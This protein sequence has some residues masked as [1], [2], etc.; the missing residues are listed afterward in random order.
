MIELIVNKDENSK[1]IAVVENGKLVEIYEENEESKKARNEGN[2]YLGIVKD[3]IPGMQ[4]AFVDI[5]TEKNSFIHVKDVIPQVDEKIE[6]RPNV[7][8]K[9][10]IKP[11]QKIL[12]QIQKDSNDKKG[13]RTSTHIK[14]T[15]KYLVLMPNTNIVTISQKIVDEK[16][17]QR[18]L[19]I[20]KVELPE[21]TGAILRTAAEHK[22]KEEIK[23]D[24]EQLMEKWEKIKT[25]FNNGK[26]SPEVLFRSP[27]IIEKIILDLP[28][29]RIEKIEV[30]DQDEYNEI[31]EM[32]V[33]M[34][35]NIKIEL[36][37][38]LLEKYELRKQIEK[39]KQRKIWLNCGGFITID[40][41]EALIA[42]V[43]NSGKFTGKSTL[44]ETIYK[45]NYEATI[46]IAKQLR[47]R[48]IGGIIIIDY[49]DMLKPENKEKIENLLKECLKQDRAKTQVEGF[50]NL[51]LM[52]LTRKHICSHNS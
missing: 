8:I 43:V 48:D 14:L 42:I 32:L 2:I 10:V 47:L 25:K 30:N 17:K 52:E 45:V 27:S 23:K 39:S 44:E 24:F 6:K 35:E 18:L 9:D 4:A 38:G 41:T 36:K 21:N 1:V 51:N 3:I 34:D 19:D 16:E 40:P 20:I 31:K 46:E 29:D 7:K 49:I 33:D 50:T 26:N 22:S 11:N 5:G 15:G 28:E 37:D 12:I 13:A